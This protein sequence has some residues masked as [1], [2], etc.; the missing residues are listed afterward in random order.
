MLLDNNRSG[1]PDNNQFFL[2]SWITSNFNK[3]KA[4][5]TII[6]AVR[7][8]LNFQIIN[9]ISLYLNYEYLISSTLCLR[10]T[11][12]FFYPKGVA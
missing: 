6:L 7:F 4:L 10:P 8:G 1:I 5:E 9:L 11:D 2:N 12:N 3:I